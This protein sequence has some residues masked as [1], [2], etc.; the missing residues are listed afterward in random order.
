MALNI[1]RWHRGRQKHADMVEAA[2][3]RTTN[4]TA[5]KESLTPIM[6]TALKESADLFPPL[7][8][9]VG[10]LLHIHEMFNKIKD[11][12]KTSE[13][14]KHQVEATLQSL[15]DAVP[16]GAEIMPE[17]QAA[18]EQYSSALEAVKVDLHAVAC[19]KNR[20]H[21]YLNA[22]RD[23]EVLMSTG[24]HLGNASEVLMIAVS[25]QQARSLQ[26]VS[27]DV[28]DTKL[29]VANIQT[30]LTTIRHLHLCT[31]VFLW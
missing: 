5:A 30:H 17:L 13:R 24:R 15:A 28:K 10:S 19:R 29:Q 9:S 7:R 3:P 23:E 18:L 12:S 25:I 16:N 4:Q 6:M 31:I 22:K 11:N 14:L 26:V 1:G 21:R 2:R 27:Q 20:L 8:N